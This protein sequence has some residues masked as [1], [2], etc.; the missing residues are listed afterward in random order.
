MD[1]VFALNAHWPKFWFLER[2]L[3]VGPD[4]RA[5]GADTYRIPGLQKPLSAV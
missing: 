5:Y 4:K 3:A 1:L 2:L